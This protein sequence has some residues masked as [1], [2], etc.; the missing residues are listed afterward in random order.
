MSLYR[1]VFRTAKV[2]TEPW[3]FWLQGQSQD[4]RW[5]YVSN[6]SSRIVKAEVI[7]LQ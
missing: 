7:P 1:I 4:P 2:L 3:S 6:E 5:W